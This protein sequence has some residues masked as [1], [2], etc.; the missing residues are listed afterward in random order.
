M[1]KEWEVEF[2]GGPIDGFYEILPFSPPIL[3]RTVEGRKYVYS[4]ATDQKG[5][6]IRYDYLDEQQQGVRRD[7]PGSPV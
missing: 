7:G 1:T 5:G 3:V 4:K 2:Y 6:T